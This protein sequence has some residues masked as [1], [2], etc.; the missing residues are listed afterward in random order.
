MIF[1]HRRARESVESESYYVSMTDM[2]VGVVF[3]FIIM[4]SFFALHYRET[5][6]AVTKAADKQTVALLQT[7]GPMQAIQ[8]TIEV[9]A[10]KKI[11]CLPGS[12]LVEG[13]APGDSN[14]HC[15]AYS[16]T[17]ASQEEAQDVSQQ[18]ASDLIVG[19]GDTPVTATKGGPGTLTFDAAK[20]FMDGANVLTPEGQKTA[21]M[22]AAQLVQKLPCYGYGQDTTGCAQKLKVN[23]IYVGA[24]IGFD[25]FTDAGRAAQALAID[26]AVAFHDA[27]VKAQPQLQTITTK[28]GP[29]LRVSSNAWSVSNANSAD[30]GRISLHFEVTAQP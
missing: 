29:L 18:M 10:Q 2:L 8:T 24:G 28:S 30:Q 23:A 27:M 1:S 5:T 20:L 19:L 17:V 15:F 22:A 14:R 7:A 12:V 6:E 9:D 16:N 21:E 11:V 3:I 25:P 26:R 4:L 13:E